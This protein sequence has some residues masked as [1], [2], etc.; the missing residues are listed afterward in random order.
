MNWK[1]CSDWPSSGRAT[2]MAMTIAAKAVM[3]PTSTSSLLAVRLRRRRLVDLGMGDLA[4]LRRRVRVAAE[5]GVDVEGEDGRDRIDL[6][7]GRGDD[8]RDQRRE[9]EAEHARR[10]D[11]A[12]SSDRP[13]RA[14][15]SPGASI[16]AAMPG[17]TT[18]TGISSL[19]IGGEHHA[20]LRLGEVLRGERALDDILVEA[21]IAEVRDP[22][23]ADQHRKAGQILV[24]RA[25]ARR[26]SCR[27]ARAAALGQRLRS[28]RG[29]RRRRR[30]G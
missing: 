22:H 7:R 17:S 8:R 29:C 16:T 24:V 14:C 26:G 27:N 19:R 12:S 30:A 20:L 28:R 21:P 9:D 25:V 11:S 13:G 1:A 10:A 4:L 3:R 15:S 23:P 2:R 6:G 5:L 18:I